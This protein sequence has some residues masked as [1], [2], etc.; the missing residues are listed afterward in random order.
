MQYGVER[1]GRKHGRNPNQAAQLVR[2][3]DKQIRDQLSAIKLMGDRRYDQG[4][5]F[6]LNSSS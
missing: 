1:N 6:W 5:Q 2:W 3:I 4:F